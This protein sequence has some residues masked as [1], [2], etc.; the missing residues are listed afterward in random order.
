MYKKHFDAWYVAGLG[1][2]RGL[3]TDDLAHYFKAQNIRSVHYFDQIADA[4]F[5]ALSDAAACDRIVAFGSF[6]TIT[7]VEQVRKINHESVWFNA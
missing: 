5:A 6:Y 2:E 3:S 4:W 1:V 7:A